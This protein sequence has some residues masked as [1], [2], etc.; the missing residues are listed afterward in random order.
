MTQRAGLY[1]KHFQYSY[2][3]KKGFE[4]LIPTPR[5]TSIEFQCITSCQRPLSS[6]YSC[7][8]T[9]DNG[10]TAQRKF[11]GNSAGV[12]ISKLSSGTTYNYNAS[13]VFNNVAVDVIDAESVTT[14]GKCLVFCAKHAYVY[15]YVPMYTVCINL[16]NSME[17]TNF[18][19][20]VVYYA[21][22]P[23]FEI[24]IYLYQSQFKYCVM[25]SPIGVI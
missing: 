21:L 10:A 9:L 19:I 17:C 2:L 14:L 24:H 23:L 13:V 5:E 1:T 22:S 3:V 6:S 7:K 12:T 16:C 20:T 15:V 18:F 25:F 4:D 8:I 11:V